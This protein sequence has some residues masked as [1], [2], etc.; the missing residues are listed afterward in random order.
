MKI[1]VK[2]FFLVSI[3]LVSGKVLSQEDNQIINYVNEIDGLWR[4]GAT[5]SA[6][7]YSLKIY[8][9][10]QSLF[11]EKMQNTFSQYIIY[12]YNKDYASKFIK[13]LYQRNIQNI[14][15]IIAPI[16][17]LNAITETNDK[18]SVEILIKSFYKLL[19]NVY[20]YKYKTESYGLLVL[21][22]MTLKGID[23]KDLYYNFINTIIRN[24]KS[25]PYIDST[26]VKEGRKQVIR[27]WCRFILSYSY[28]QLYQQ[29]PDS[30][31]A[32]IQ[33]QLA[34]RYSPDFSDKVVSWAYGYDADYLNKNNK[35]IGYK[36]D[37]FEYLVRKKKIVE[38]LY[39]LTQLVLC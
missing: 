33:L 6:I 34:S 24:V 14:N 37:Y 8:N 1:F 31:D 3:L 36:S 38:A 13:R 30:K 19:S 20:N 32:E 9:S 4:R 27:A 21:Q 17:I 10:D 2:T 16:Y 28:Y 29:D 26:T 39:V 12:G 23:D 7:E 22:Q 5:D 18:D 35:K 15:A 25:N 11:R